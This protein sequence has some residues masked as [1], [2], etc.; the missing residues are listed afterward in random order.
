V[1][2]HG[3]LQ[4]CHGQEHLSNDAGKRGTTAAATN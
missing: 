1:T 2:H 4:L 3:L